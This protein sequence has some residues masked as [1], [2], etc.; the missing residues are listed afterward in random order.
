M[1]GA[2]IAKSILERIPISAHLDYT[3]LSLISGN[4]IT[5]DLLEYYDDGLFN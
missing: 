3:V 5:L 2:M 1:L 4:P